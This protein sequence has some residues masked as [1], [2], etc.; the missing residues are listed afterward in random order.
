MDK[1]ERMFGHFGNLSPDELRAKVRQ[2]RADRRMAKAKPA[3]VK[4]AK[5]DTDSAKTKAQKLIQKAGNLELLERLLKE[6]GHG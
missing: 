4:K 1:L 6:A 2:T 3:A 5:R